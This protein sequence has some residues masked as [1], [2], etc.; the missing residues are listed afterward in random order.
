MNDHQQIEN[1]AVCHRHNYPNRIV[2][3]L[4]KDEVYYDSCD[5]LVHELDVA[6]LVSLSNSFQLFIAISPKF[7]RHHQ[8]KG[9]TQPNTHQG[10]LLYYSC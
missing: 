7:Q 9:G 8:T 3:V 10:Q 4:E 6:I 1:D 5:L 2:T